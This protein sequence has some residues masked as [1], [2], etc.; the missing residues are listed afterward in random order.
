[1][2]SFCMKTLFDENVGLNFEFCYNFVCQAF[3]AKNP[4]KPNG[5]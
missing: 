3:M 1:M 4:E 2:P 5:F